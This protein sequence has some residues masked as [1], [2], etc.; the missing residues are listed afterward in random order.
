MMKPHVSIGV[1]LAALVVFFVCGSGFAQYSHAAGIG[2]QVGTNQDS[3]AVTTGGEVDVQLSGLSNEQLRQLLIEELKK[4][5]AVSPP[6][7]V[8]VS[9]PGSVLGTLLT[10]LSGGQDRYETQLRYLLAGIRQVPSDLGR[11]FTSICPYGTTGGALRN[12]I[13]V[14]VFIGVGFGVEFL[15]RRLVLP[16]YFQHPARGPEEP[17]RMSEKFSASF[18]KIIPEVL[19]LVIFFGAAYLSYMSFIWTDWAN[20]QLFFMAVLLVITII[21][22][23]IIIS[24]IIF[25][26]TIRTFRIIPLECPQARLYHSIIVITFAYINTVVMIA[27]VLQRLGAEF[28]T[29]MLVQLFGATLLLAVTGAAVLIFRKS[30]RDSIL[31]PR[32]STGPEPGW[33]RRQFASVWHILAL[34]Y[35]VLLWFLLLSDMAGMVR[36][37]GEPISTARGRGAF[38]FSFF[39]VP[40]WMVIDSIVRWLVKYTM[41]ALQLYRDDYDDSVEP[42]DEELKQRRREQAL[43]I[44][45]NAIARLAV[46]GAL[47]VW[48]A[49]LWNI[50]IPFVS[51][52][53]DV[54]LD[55]VIIMT[56]ALLF[57]QMISSWIER[58][59][60]ESLPEEE[61]DDQE[62]SE[63]G[64]GAAKGRAYTLLPMVR[65]FIGSVLVIMVTMMILSSI[66]VDIGPLLA[67]AGVVGLA[68]GFGA[69]KLVADM[70]SGF[71]YLLD[72]AFRVGEYLTAGSVSG[73]V[74]QITL[75]N[76]F[77]RHHRGMLQIVPHSEMGAITN[78]M[79]GG[80][81]VKF[82]LDFP[83][84]APIDKIRKIIKKVGQQMLQNEEYGKDFIRPL[85]SQGVREITNS[86]M[87]IRAKFTAQPGTHF[88]IRREAY[89][90][91]TEALNAQGIYYAH[92]KVIVDVPELEADHADKNKETTP[93]EALKALAGAAALRTIEEEEQAAQQGGSQDDD[94]MG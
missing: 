87:T 57:W 11:V 27:V 67:G 77:L 39:A 66:G 50:V 70:F 73:T 90:L 61:E 65:K 93:K 92:R 94:A 56:L 28:R 5:P 79:R 2:Q 4:D 85:K 52:L 89:R 59:I 78:Y 21:R 29:T 47:F 32:G 46:I 7:T 10:R 54:L 36:P 19:G 60:A 86:V 58:K 55:A 45:T 41:L 3:E 26:P 14:A 13:W 83:Y 35:L 42:D 34:A 33:G 75:R 38:I 9:G 51:T 80:I 88:V 91:I 84:D 37:A 49:S 62:E 53:A 63:W 82:N 16:N 12:L 64:G 44:R 81:I 30:I 1:L 68:I 31:R 6:K 25:S 20:L 22:V 17:F 15:F 48:L 40:I 69:Q 24:D 18:A 74:E 71:F 8:S 72:D 43:Y 76:V 23:F